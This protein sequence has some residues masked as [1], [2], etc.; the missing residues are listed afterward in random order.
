MRAP[1]QRALDRPDRRRE[2]CCARRVGRRRRSRLTGDDIEAYQRAGDALNEIAILVRA[3]FQMREFE[4]RF[5]ALGVPY[6]VIGGHDFMSAPKFVTPMPISG[7]SH[8]PTMIW[9]LNAFATSP[10]AGLAMWPCRHSTMP[11]DARTLRF[12]APQP[13]WCKRKN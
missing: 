6:R 10:D 9:R 2:S 5:I 11:P 1:W 3:S 8:K 13:N 7:L 12:T 4:D